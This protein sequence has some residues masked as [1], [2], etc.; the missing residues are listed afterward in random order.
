MGRAA[1]GRGHAVCHRR[2]RR[3]NRTRARAARPNPGVGR[4]MAI[5][6]SFT[7]GQEVDGP[8]T[9]PARVDTARLDLEVVNF[10]CGFYG[11]DQ[12]FLRY[13]READAL[14]PDEVWLG[15]QPSAL[16]R[17]LGVYPPAQRHWTNVLHVKPRFVFGTSGRIELVRSPAQSLDDLVTLLSDQ[18]RFLE[19]V[20]RHDAWVQRSWSA[21][22]GF[23][24][25]LWHHS[26]FARLVVTA[27]EG[28]GREAKPEVLDPE[29]E[30]RRLD[31]ALVREL[32]HEVRA[33]GARLRVLI[34]P[35][36]LD[37]ADRA[38][39]GRAYWDGFVPDLA[40]AGIE[41]ADLAAAFGAV[42]AQGEDR[43]WAPEGHYSAEG[44][45]IARRRSPIISLG[46]ADARKGR[47]SCTEGSCKKTRAR[48][49]NRPSSRFEK[50]GSP[51]QP[52]GL[53]RSE[54]RRN[55][56]RTR[57]KWVLESHQPVGRT[58]RADG[59]EKSCPS[60]ASCCNESSR[61]RGA[62]EPRNS[63]LLGRRVSRGSAGTAWKRHQPT[64][65][66]QRADGIEKSCPQRSFR[67]ASR[68]A[69]SGTSIE[70]GFSRRARNGGS[71]PG[72]T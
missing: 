2:T 17:I 23:G 26:A 25:R 24:S 12:A 47:T 56:E 60:A 72:C 10:G 13:R 49:A 45:R 28:G 36:R 58:R 44:N 20:G 14:R 11:I 35:D 57:R 71:C 5:G 46:R 37:L 42:G 15:V 27:L 51:A 62:F 32:A 4:V 67:A 22:Q 29:S 64:G 53:R 3:S 63:K 18:N 69:G 68:R 61:A 48:S 41:C 6:Y 1:L 21:Y 33:N 8:E 65:R 7:F 38:E 31:L 40:E 39:H 66:T 30:I 52:T 50:N 16:T 70:P 54:P 43:Y 34:L 19:R 9:W 59:I 55:G